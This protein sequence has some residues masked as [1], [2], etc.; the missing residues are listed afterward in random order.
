LVKVD[1]KALDEWYEELTPVLYHPKNPY[2]RVDILPT[3]RKI[4]VEIDGVTIAEADSGVLSLWETNLRPRWY[5]PKTSIVNWALLTPTETHTGCPYKGEASYYSVTANGKE[6]K[7]VVWWY[8]YPITESATIAGMVCFYNE[9]VDTYID[10]VKEDRQ[11][12]G[13]SAAAK[14]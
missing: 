1:F 4:R 7:D 10:G 13:A 8:P 9:K 5:L 3:A 14:L 11:A 12:T 6:H 2:T